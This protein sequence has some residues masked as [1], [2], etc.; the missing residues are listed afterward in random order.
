MRFVCCCN[1]FAHSPLPSRTDPAI[2]VACMPESADC[3]CAIES[4]TGQCFDDPNG[5]LLAVW[6]QGNRD[7]P[8][9]TVL[10]AHRKLQSRP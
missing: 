4:Q 7:A 1:S 5:T 10:S 3:F 6:R 8:R 9:D 2:V